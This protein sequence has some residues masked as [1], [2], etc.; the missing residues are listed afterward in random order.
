M[1]LPPDEV[2]SFVAEMQRRQ[3]NRA[4][5]QGTN[6]AWEGT[7][8]A[9][10][11]IADFV[12]G[13]LYDVSP[14]QQ[15]ISDYAREQNPTAFA[16]GSLVNPVDAAAMFATGGTSLPWRMGAQ[17]AYGAG[18]GLLTSP[19]GERGEAAALGGIF[20]PIGELAGTVGQRVVREIKGLGREVVGGVTAKGRAGELVQHAKDQGF[21][22]TPGDLRGSE[23]LRVLEEITENPISRAIIGGK[24]EANQALL[25]RKVAR[26]FGVDA[27]QIGPAELAEGRKLISQKFDESIGQLGSVEIPTDVAEMVGQFVPRSQKLGRYKGLD[28]GYLTGPEAKELR[29][30]LTQQINSP[31]IL[32]ED[33]F[34]LQDIVEEIDSTILD[35]LGDEGAALYREAREQYRNLM[36][37]SRAAKRGT[38]ITPSGDVNAPSY[39]SAMQPDAVMLER[40]DVVMPETEDLMNTVDAFA[41]PLRRAI[42]SS[43]TSERNLVNSLLQGTGSIPGLL[44][45]GAGGYIGRGL[46]STAPVARTGVSAAL[47]RAKAEA[48]N[49]EE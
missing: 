34:V 37:A 43:G 19:E 31:N 12:A 6:P 11:N 26:S 21:K 15:A 30:V 4:T 33:A 14:E 3:A 5:W 28:Y 16:M 27:D 47:M 8:S 40:R 22:L 13:P 36:T 39:R 24:Q 48:E 2:D 23:S 7:K 46:T 25:N 9:M 10:R 29:E 18:S 44:G 1:G 35:Q 17:A 41:G 45:L 20:G 49:Y 32:A 42:T 38:G